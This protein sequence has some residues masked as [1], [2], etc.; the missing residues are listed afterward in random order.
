VESDFPLLSSVEQCR[1]PQDLATQIRACAFLGQLA[2]CLV[3]LTSYHLYKLHTGMHRN[4][5]LK[6]QQGPLSYIQVYDAFNGLANSLPLRVQ[7]IKSFGWIAA[8]CSRW[9]GLP[10]WILF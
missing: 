1:R 7:G 8:K 10:P 6:Y 9:L 4:S 2:P 3:P 5:S